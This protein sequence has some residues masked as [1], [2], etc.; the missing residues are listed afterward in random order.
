MLKY[1]ISGVVINQLEQP[2][3]ESFLWRIRD[4][5]QNPEYS[6]L[7]LLWVQG[8]LE[9]ELPGPLFE[10]LNGDL[11]IFLEEKRR[12]LDP[13]GLNALENCFSTIK[14]KQAAN[15]SLY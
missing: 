8:A 10:L 4:L 9:L 3:V 7:L 6:P 12:E 2:V 14:K 1:C 15:L 11:Q 13:R 5:L